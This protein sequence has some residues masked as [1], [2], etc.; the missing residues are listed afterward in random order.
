P[1]NHPLSLGVFGYAGSRLS[2]LALTPEHDPV[3]QRLYSSLKRG[4]PRLDPYKA[5]VLLILGSGLN[6]RDTMF[7]SPELPQTTIRVDIDPRV[8]GRKRVSAPVV[9]DVGA[10]LRWMLEDP[11]IRGALENTSRARNDWLMT[12]RNEQR[13]YDADNMKSKPGKIHP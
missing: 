4:D 2:T 10:F 11:G 1:E 5:D 3:L 13:Y 6:Q 7:W 12:I 8:M 9:G